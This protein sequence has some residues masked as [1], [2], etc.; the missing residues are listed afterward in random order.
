[1]ARAS[2][3]R[4]SARRDRK[5]IAAIGLRRFDL[6]DG[7]LMTRALQQ[8]RRTTHAPAKRSL[9]RSFRE[10]P[11]SATVVDWDEAVFRSF[12]IAYKPDEWKVG[13]VPKMKKEAMPF[14][15]GGGSE[16][17]AQPSGRASAEFTGKKATNFK[18]T[19]SWFVAE[20]LGQI[21]SFAMSPRFSK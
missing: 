3:A 4:A 21:D 17:D 5:S 13:G 9:A 2:N 12:G 14:G 15:P 18:P 16:A 19:A 7:C 8:T 10:L 20:T 11:C 1:M 6:L